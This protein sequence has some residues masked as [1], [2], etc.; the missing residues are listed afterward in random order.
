MRATNPC[1]PC[2]RTH[3]YCMYLDALWFA[4]LP[5][6]DGTNRLVGLGMTGRGGLH[7]TQNARLHW[8]RLAEGLAAY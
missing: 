8:E 1:N 7:E 6:K 5:R 2:Y 3:K 4:I